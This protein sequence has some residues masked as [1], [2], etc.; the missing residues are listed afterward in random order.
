M[1][2]KPS[3]S[4]ATLLR[5]D[6]NATKIVNW[7]NT[8]GW[9]AKLTGAT[10]VKGGRTYYRIKFADGELAWMTTLGKIQSFL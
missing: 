5:C 3:T 9:N 1:N 2:K 10:I 8:R 7:I 4:A 6:A